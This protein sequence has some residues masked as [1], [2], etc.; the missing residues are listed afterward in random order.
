[1]RVL[2]ITEHAALVETA[3]ENRELLGLVEMVEDGSVVMAADGKSVSGK[4]MAILEGGAAFLFI[5]NLEELFVVV[6]RGYDYN[7]LE[8][9]GGGTDKRDATYVYFLDDILFGSTAGNSLLERIEV[10]NDEVDFRYLVFAEL[11]AIT[12]HVA[13]T[14][15][16]AEHLGMECLDTSAKNRGITRQGFDCDSVDAEI[17]DELVS[18]TR[19]VNGDA[20]CVEGFND[21]LKAVL[22]KDRNEG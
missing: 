4:A 1:M 19:R 17:L 15:Y 11:F 5:V 6:Y 12:I 18:T 14:Q 9:F 2:A 22:I 16:A 20:I 3:F 13:A 8:V 7:V 10:D 21:V